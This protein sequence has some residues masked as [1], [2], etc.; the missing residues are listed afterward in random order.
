LRTDSDDAYAEMC[1]LLGRGITTERLYGD[2]LDAFRRGV[3]LAP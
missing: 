1:E 2:Y 3:E